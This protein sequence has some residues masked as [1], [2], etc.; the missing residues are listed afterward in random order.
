M[1]GHEPLSFGCKSGEM[2]IRKWLGTPGIVMF[3][4]NAA[5]SLFMRRPAHAQREFILRFAADSR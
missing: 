3:A 1:V 4:K 2:E 5:L